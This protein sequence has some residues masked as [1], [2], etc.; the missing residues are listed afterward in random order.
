MSSDVQVKFN[1]DGKV[2]VLRG[3]GVRARLK[4]HCDNIKRRA[5]AMSESG[6]AD[7]T[8]VVDAHSVSA[9]GHVW[10]KDAATIASNKK[11][12]ALVKCLSEEP[13]VTMHE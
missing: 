10:A 5:D 4:I 8:V 1:R 2:S 13:G 12:D 3:P 6:V 11:H 7:Y 9:H